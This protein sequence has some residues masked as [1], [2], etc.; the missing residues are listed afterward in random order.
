MNHLN[1]RVRA[2]NGL[3][4][5]DQLRGGGQAQRLGWAIHDNIHVRN[6]AG[7]FQPGH[8][9]ELQTAANA[10]VKALQQ[11]LKLNQLVKRGQLRPRR[12][13]L[14]QQRQCLLRCDRFGVP[15]WATNA[16]KR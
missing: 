9:L 2:G 3:Q 14:W 15:F 6:R 1:V 4:P 5:L 10:P 12:V 13:Q 16:A 8:Q 7:H 11:R